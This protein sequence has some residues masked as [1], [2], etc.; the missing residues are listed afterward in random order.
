MHK[1]WRDR[2]RIG[3]WRIERH[4]REGPFVLVQD[5]TETQERRAFPLDLNDAE[6]LGL[7]F[8]GE[9]M[10][11]LMPALRLQEHWGDDIPQAQVRDEVLVRVRQALQRAG[12]Q[13]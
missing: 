5:A 9:A 1:V 6:S 7:D 11:L 2:L 8:N 4:R 10:T 13:V 3:T 12:V